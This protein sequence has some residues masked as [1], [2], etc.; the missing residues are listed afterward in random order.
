MSNGRLSNE[1]QSA[2]PR[3]A[4]C[5]Q[6]LGNLR[7]SLATEVEGGNGT[8]LL[9]MT[10]AP[11]FGTMRFIPSHLGVVP[12]RQTLRITPRRWDCIVRTYGLVF[13]ADRM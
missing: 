12:E 10:N 13:A 7:Y 11:L 5:A 2:S 3:A 8:L 9:E 6:N 4:R 1:A